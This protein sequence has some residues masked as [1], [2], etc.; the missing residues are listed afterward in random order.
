MMANQKIIFIKS[1]YRQSYYE[2]VDLLNSCIEDRFQ[3]PGYEKYKRLESLFLK[4]CTSV[5]TEEEVAE[6]CQ[7]Y[8][9]DF[10]HSILQT[11]LQV[12]HTHFSSTQTDNH[13]QK[14][15]IF[16]IKNTFCPSLLANCHICRKS[17]VCCS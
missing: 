11:Q 14:I 3:Q 13:P 1:F 6:I 17:I 12:F 9:D 16:D 4:A 2:A 10:Y 5:D 8:K 7:F 15:D